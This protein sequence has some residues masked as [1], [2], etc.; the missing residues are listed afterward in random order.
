MKKILEEKQKDPPSV[1]DILAHFK[2]N[3][4]FKLKGIFFGA[5]LFIGIATLFFL[6]IEKIFEFVGVDTDFTDGFRDGFNGLLNELSP[7]FFGGKFFLTAAIIYI[8]FLLLAKGDPH[9][10]KN[11]KFV[12][13]I[14]ILSIPKLISR[15]VVILFAGFF[16]GVLPLWA[17]LWIL[18]FIF[19]FQL[20]L[21][22]NITFQKVYYREFPKEYKLDFGESP[23]R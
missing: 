16:L 1:L 9:Y 15:S 13:K 14:P 3:E 4:I 6:F 22:T 8:V 23:P 19:I 21:I 18:S 17:S 11:F 7:Y 20:L 10:F 12:L 2:F 5:N